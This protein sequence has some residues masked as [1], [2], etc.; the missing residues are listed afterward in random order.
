MIIKKRIQMCVQIS[1]HMF[2]KIFAQRRAYNLKE[3]KQKGE[4]REGRLGDKTD[5]CSPFKW[6]AVRLYWHYGDLKY[7]MA[8]L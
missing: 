3:Q 7:K 6:H 5:Y 2:S 4:G 8:V 1:E